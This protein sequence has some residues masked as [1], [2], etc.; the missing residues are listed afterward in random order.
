MFH[1]GLIMLR[2]PQLCG[3]L[4]S[5]HRRIERLNEKPFRTGAP[6]DPFRLPTADLPLVDLA[7]PT[8]RTLPTQLHLALQRTPFASLHLCHGLE[9]TIRFETER[10]VIRVYAVDHIYSGVIE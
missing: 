6:K 5:A 4:G 2:T 7:L 10:V 9:A 1:G 3:L 8:F